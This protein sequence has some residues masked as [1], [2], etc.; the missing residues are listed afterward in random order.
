M[1]GAMTESAVATLTENIVF[2]DEHRPE[3]EADH[4]GKWILV[5]D[6]RIE[7]FFEDFQAAAADAVRRFGR[8]P[9]LIRQI[10]APSAALPASVMFGPLTHAYNTLRV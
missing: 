4:F 8:G 7:G 1:I 3:L 2:Y 10:G 6:R 5:H 9:Y